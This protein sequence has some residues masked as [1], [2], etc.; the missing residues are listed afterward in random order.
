VAG[1]EVSWSSRN[2]S[3][4]L[5]LARG[6][7]NKMSARMSLSVPRKESTKYGRAGIIFGQTMLA[8]ACRVRM[9]ADRGRGIE[10]YLTLHTEKRGT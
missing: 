4:T 2:G 10:P 6:L 7:L 9:E 8:I 5:L 1:A 3:T